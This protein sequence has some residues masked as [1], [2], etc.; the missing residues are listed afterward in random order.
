MKVIDM[1]LRPPFGGFLDGILYKADGPNKMAAYRGLEPSPSVQSRSMEK[2][3]EE[4]DAVGVRYG[5]VPIRKTNGGR[6]EELLKLLAAYPHRFIGIPHIDPLEGV[7]ALEEIARYVLE[8]PCRGIIM[9]PAAIFNKENWYITDE[10]AF[11]VY[12]MCQKHGIPLLFTYGGRLVK[13]QGYLDPLYADRLG[14]LFPELNMVFCHGGWPHITQMCHAAAQHPNIHISADVYMMDFTAGYEAYVTGADYQLQDQFLFG[15]SYPVVSLKQ[16]VEKYAR[17][18]RP[19]V[20]DKVL[21]H[22]AARL[23]SLTEEP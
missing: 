4:M 19:E 6:N 5:V 3:L 20:L 2:L 10:R 9:E 13:D 12:E 22:N 11:P 17:M 8:G 15:S 16:A 18:L 7:K 1:R 23:F 14:Y 21:Y